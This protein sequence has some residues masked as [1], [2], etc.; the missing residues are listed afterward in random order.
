M[1][2]LA[3][4]LIQF[5]GRVKMRAPVEIMIDQ[6]DI[7]LSDD[8][9]DDAVAFRELLI[10]LDILRQVGF[11]DGVVGLQDRNGAVRAHGIYQLRQPGAKTLAEPGVLA[12]NVIAADEDDD[13]IGMKPTHLPIVFLRLHELH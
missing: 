8:L 5:L 10:A 4:L 1:D 12:D 13:D 11:G 2:G 9:P 3:Q 7:V 6:Q